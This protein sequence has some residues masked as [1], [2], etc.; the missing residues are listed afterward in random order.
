MTVTVYG[1]PNCDQIKKT[2]Q[3]LAEQQ[4]DY[5]FHDYK[6]E[7]IDQQTLS[8]WVAVAGLDSLLNR[9][10]TTWRALDEARKQAAADPDQAIALMQEQPS[11]IK[12]P[13]IQIGDEPGQ[14]LV[15]FSADALQQAFAWRS[16]ESA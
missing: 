15:G 14:L 3:W 11:L 1:I 7:G 2:R 16:A 5:R 12:R 4:I 13:V 8:R 9:R 10:G 6:R